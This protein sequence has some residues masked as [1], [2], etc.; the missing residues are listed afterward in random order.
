MSLSVRYTPP[1]VDARVLLAAAAAGAV[2][3]GADLIL[4]ASQPLVPVDTGELKASGKVEMTG[5]HQARISYDATAPDGYPYGVR[6]HED[7]QLQ[8]PNGGQA[9]FLSQPMDTEAHAV[10]AVL[11]AALRAAL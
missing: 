8:H 9:H 10:M 1:P 11:A 2:K 4:D 5:P 3:T 6:Q 7:L